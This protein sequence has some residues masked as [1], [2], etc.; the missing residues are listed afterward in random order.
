MSLADDLDPT[1]WDLKTATVVLDDQLGLV[2]EQVEVDVDPAGFGVPDDVV[3]QFLIDPEQAQAY[4]LWQD[5]AIRRQIQ[6]HFQANM[7]ALEAFG[8]RADG[9]F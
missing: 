9:F 3:E 7:P 4:V 6:M 8:M 5:L 1:A 2:F